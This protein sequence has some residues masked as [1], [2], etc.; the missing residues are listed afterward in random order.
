MTSRPSSRDS[1]AVERDPA[2]LFAPPAVVRETCGD[3]TML[4]RSARSL[5]T[6]PASLGHHLDR[7]ASDAPE[8]D[9]LA[10]RNG[11]GSWRRVTYAAARAA[12]R[13][14]AAGLL[15]RELGPDRPVAILSDNSIDQALLSFAAMYV[16]I[17]VAPISPSYSLA[18]TDHAKLRSIVALANP[19]LIFVE[20]APSY[21]RAL[22]AVRAVS[23]APILS[24]TPGGYAGAAPLESLLA[25]DEAAVTAAFEAVGPDTIAKL[26]FTSGSTGEPKGV[27]NTQRMMCSNQQARAQ[28][29]PFL[30][31]TPPVMLDWLPWSHTF[32]GNFNLNMVLRHG[33]TLYIDGGRPMPGRFETTLANLGG[34]PPTVY[35][36]V[37]RGYDMLVTA[38]RDD[39]ALRNAFFAR[40]Q[41]MFYAAAALPQHLWDALNDLSTAAVG[42]AVPIVSGWGSTETGPLVTDCHFQA[43]RSGVIGVPIAGCEVKLVPVADKLEIRVRGENITPGYWRRPDLTASHFDDEGFYRIGDAV[44]FVDPSQPEKGLL[45]DGRIVEDFKLDSG[46]WVNVGMLRVRAIAALAPVAQDIVLTGHDRSDIGF[47]IFPNVAGCRSLCTDL[48]AAADVDRVLADPKVRACVERGLVELRASGKGTSTFATRAL[49]MAEPPSIDAGEITDKGYINQRAVLTRRAALVHALHAAV[50]GRDVVVLP[51]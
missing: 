13:R 9:F 31:T 47:L 30:A 37:P 44:R 4:L 33:G 15:R 18:S 1:A 16:G 39:A 5:D 48:P 2:R 14:L 43:E 29:W 25:T 12:I 42:S 45:F 23:D 38:L 50:P 36:N 28:T 41:V 20:H 24:S 34:V 51:E 19:G 6:Y 21:A 10:E 32:G 8:R 40:L 35:A 17:P 22:D 26:L 11:D 3:G 7:W 49:L 27:I 46:T